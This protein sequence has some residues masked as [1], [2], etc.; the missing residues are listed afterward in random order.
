MILLLIASLS[1]AA[2]PV[3]VDT[4]L[5]QLAAAYTGPPVADTVTAEITRDDGTI[6]RVSLVIESAGVGR[7][8]SIRVSID[9]FTVWAADGIVRAE[10]STTG[11]SRLALSV[12]LEGLSASEMIEA[13]LPLGPL[14]QLWSIEPGGRAGCG[15]L[16]RIVFD[17]AESNDGV[18]TVTGSAADR[19]VSITLD[20][21]SGRV[22]SMFAA[23]RDGTI[24]LRAAP[25][26]PS[27]PETWPIPVDGRRI[28][29]RL[30]QLAPSGPAIEIGSLL[31]DLVLVREGVGQPLSAILAETPPAPVATWTLLIFAESEFLE[32]ARAAASTIHSAAVARSM[33]LDPTSAYWLRHRALIVEVVR[34]EFLRPTQ[35]PADAPSHWRTPRPDLTLD[36]LPPAVG[37]VA[38]AI[39]SGR[40]VGAVQPLESPKD[41]GALLD[42]MLIPAQN[43]GD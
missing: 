29:E 31:P 32:A 18:I 28:V 13:K 25:A 15:A 42:Q 11:A 40:V 24:S 8:R 27:D 4:A 2:E 3:P 5:A 33:V 20:A 43:R 26:T 12:E 7:E 14:P 23:M 22:E 34:E 10:R 39:D 30:D 6:D 19:N 1:I 37:P 17:A 38:I 36:R 21:A 41:F 35:A 9:E 16:G